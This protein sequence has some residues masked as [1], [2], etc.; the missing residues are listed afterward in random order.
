MKRPHT[1]SHL[2][3][4]GNCF[5]HAVFNFDH[6]V[7]IRCV[8]NPNVYTWNFLKCRNHSGIN[9]CYHDKMMIMIMIGSLVRLLEAEASM[10]HH[11]KRNLC[12][13]WLL[14]GEGPRLRNGKLMLLEFL[15]PSFIYNA[16][17]ACNC[18]KKECRFHRIWTL[19]FRRVASLVL[20]GCHLKGDAFKGVHRL[21]R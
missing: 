10:T 1:L 16:K 9:P 14:E 18:Y 4:Q 20:A 17:P 13:F 11:Y 8:P 15:E 6:A 7:G 2:S 12:L 5:F 19:R 3:P 21:N